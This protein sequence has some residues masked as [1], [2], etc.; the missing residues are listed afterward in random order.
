MS[1]FTS[2]NGAVL[3]KE[4]AFSSTQVVKVITCPGSLIKLPIFPTVGVGMGINPGTKITRDFY[5]PFSFLSLYDAYP[6]KCA[7]SPNRCID[8]LER[9]I[10]LCLLLLTPAKG[11]RQAI[12]HRQLVSMT[13]QTDTATL[14][15][16]P[17]YFVCIRA[18]VVKFPTGNSYCF[19]SLWQ[20]SQL[21]SNVPYILLF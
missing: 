12:C 5:S 4:V 11:K 19:P 18:N 17:A 6:L 13:E 3:Y 10:R 15:Q 14:K 16:L 20:F 7:S 9:Q 8:C 1:L 2:F 21:L